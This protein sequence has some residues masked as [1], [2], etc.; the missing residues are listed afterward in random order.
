MSSMLNALLLLLGL[1]SPL[2]GST[3]TAYDKALNP[4]VKLAMGHAQIHDSSVG[5]RTAVSPVDEID[6]LNDVSLADTRKDVISK[7]GKPV[8]ITKDPLT[9]YT[10]YHY[11]D[12]T[13]GLFEDQVY[14]V[15]LGAGSKE[16]KVNEQ[17]V[18]LQP[19]SLTR[20]FGPADYIAEDGVVYTRG[21]SAIKIYKNPRGGI[22]GID[23]F[24]SASE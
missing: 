4:D 22:Q 15:H 5:E 21:Y 2:N 6:T 12:V 8:K 13:V 14:Y 17:W 11:K 9:G 1:L 24:D 7:K 19:A 10:E 3:P 23:L 20:I 18:E 16:M